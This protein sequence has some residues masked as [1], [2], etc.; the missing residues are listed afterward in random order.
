MPKMK[1]RSGVVSRNGPNLVTNLWVA[2]DDLLLWCRSAGERRQSRK[3]E[4]VEMQLHFTMCDHVLC[5]QI[6]NRCVKEVKC[7]SKD[8]S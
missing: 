7:D 4:N 2:D 5:V 1:M 6:S 3:Q 8:N